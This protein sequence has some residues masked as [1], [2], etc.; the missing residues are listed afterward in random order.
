[1]GGYRGGKDTTDS[2]RALDIR[3][4]HRNG[5]LK[6]HPRSVTW[7]RRG[8]E[9]GNIN[10]EGQNG[11]LLLTYRC[12]PSGG[13]RE[14]MSYSVEIVWTPC[15]YGGKRPWFLCPVSLCRRRVAVLYGG[16]VFA[17]RKC[18]DLVY[19]TQHETDYSRALR[20]LHKI[21]RG[22]GGEPGESFPDKP[23]GMHWRTLRCPS[24]ESRGGRQSFDPALVIQCVIAR[25]PCH[26][27]LDDIRGGGTV[28]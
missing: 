2:Y 3:W 13:D 12:R 22:L 18:H 16:R 26:S 11:R 10:V 14:Q 17:C 24:S 1:M 28:R 15:N 7:S 27:R 8:E 25:P 20:K 5:M 9:I 4:L 6:G 23:R 19:E 21:M